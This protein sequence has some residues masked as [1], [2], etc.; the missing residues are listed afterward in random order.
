MRNYEKL[1]HCAPLLHPILLSAIV[2]TDSV[3]VFSIVYAYLTYLH[4]NIRIV[5]ISKLNMHQTRKYSVQH[6]ILFRRL[7]ESF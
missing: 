7:D 4:I 6:N 2:C 1:V 5:Q 3:F